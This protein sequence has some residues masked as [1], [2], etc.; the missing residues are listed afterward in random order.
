MRT[1]GH[2]DDMTDV[3]RG[4]LLACARC[5]GTSVLRC[6]SHHSLSLALEVLDVFGGIFDIMTEGIDG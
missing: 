2:T 3:V 1:S 6:F 4:K 5:P